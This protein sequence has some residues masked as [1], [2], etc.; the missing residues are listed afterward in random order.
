MDI[1]RR[2]INLIRKYQTNNPFKLAKYLNINVRYVNLN[3]DT[4]GAYCRTLRRKFIGLNQDLSEEWQ[5]F[6]CAHELGHDRLHK[7]MGFYFIEQNTLF[8][9]GK[10]ERQ[11]NNFAVHLMTCCKA[12]EEHETIETFYQRNNVPVEMIGKI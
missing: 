4:R 11:A 10:Y 3:N 9:P 7:G 1:Q 12:I 8:N 6:V 5:R 2:V